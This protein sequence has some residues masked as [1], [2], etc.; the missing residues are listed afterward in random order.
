MLLPYN[1]VL[2]SYHKNTQIIR[3]T[4]LMTT[5]TLIKSKQTVWKIRFGSKSE[6]TSYYID[7]TSSLS[8]YQYKTILKRRCLLF[9]FQ[10]SRLCLFLNYSAFPSFL[11][12]FLISFLLSFFLNV[13]IERHA[14]SSHLGNSTLTER[15]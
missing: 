5:V 13:Y 10:A 4:G 11:L 14:I 7:T 12:S 2:V 3:Y 1:I 6:Q 8:V 9:M 15:T